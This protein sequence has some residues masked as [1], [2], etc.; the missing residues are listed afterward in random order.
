MAFV[1]ILGGVPAATVLIVDDEALV[2]WSPRERLEQEGHATL[3]ESQADPLLGIN[4][5]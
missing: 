1:C 4:R 5:D 2:R 3:T